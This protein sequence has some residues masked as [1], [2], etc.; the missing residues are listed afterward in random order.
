MLTVRV[1]HTFIS[2]GQVVAAG[3]VIRIPEDALPALAGLVEP[4]TTRVWLQDGELR[5]SGLVHDL[6]GAICELTANDIGL[7]R[8]LLTEHCQSYGP[9]HI[10]NIIK[11]WKDYVAVKEQA[12]MNREDD[13]EEAA[14]HFHL[15]AWLQEIRTGREIR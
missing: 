15:T 14:D 1:L 13:E 3:S 7:Q 9:A 6:S 4:I 11:A 10:G 5:S 8:R 2:N 12:G